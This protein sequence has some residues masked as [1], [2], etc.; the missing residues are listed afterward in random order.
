MKYPEQ[1]ISTQ[2]NSDSVL[3]LIKPVVDHRASILKYTF[4][5]AITVTLASFLVR[6][7]YTAAAVI[8]PDIDI[9][10]A[11]QKFGSLQDIASSVGF[12]IGVTS[13]SQL[14]SDI[15]V[16]ETILR[17]V[18]FRRYV[19][20][21]SNQPLNLIEFWGYDSDDS[22][23]N[24]ERCLK[25][26]REKVINIDV[27]KK[28][29]ILT[30]AVETT[31]STLSSDIVNAMVTQLDVYQRNFRRTNAY[32]QRKFLDQR[33]GEVQADLERSENEL[34]DFREKNR[35]I[36]DSPLL[37]LQE[38]RLGRSVDVNTAL[39]LELRKQ[40]ELVKLDEIKN[41][42]VVQVLDYARI[43]AEKSSPKRLWILILSALCTFCCSSL[44]YVYA[45][46]FRRSIAGTK[47][48][49]L[50]SE[51]QSSLKNDFNRLISF[52]KKN[53]S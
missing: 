28:T 24:Y 34:Q 47:H 20:S 25:R 33:M 3:T 9:L 29:G 43:T 40:Y 39:Y 15:L 6:N 1:D 50:L 30:L 21:S 16:S 19:T 46:N 17:P 22:L 7:K 48:E 42:P 32:E 2:E 31:E 10:T 51:I 37:S 52:M 53:P 5:I 35:R 27:N 44:Y 38:S 12:N 18:I 11:A 45:D 41:T 13:P 4:I 49:Q 8:L 36:L 23:K 14:Y 26:L